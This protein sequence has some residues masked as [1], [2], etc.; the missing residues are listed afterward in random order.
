MSAPKPPS[1]DDLLAHGPFL[2]RITRRLVRAG[3]DADD[4]MQDTWLRVLERPPRN[5]ANL[6][7]W[8]ARVTRNRLGEGRRRRQRVD[9]QP[10]ELVP[11][12]AANQA[13]AEAEL[14]RATLARTVAN[15]VLELEE[16]YRTVVVMRYFEDASTQRIA[17]RL[18][19]SPNTVGSQLRR[20]LER[21][22][23][24]L[25]RDLGQD[26]SSDL[27]VLSPLLALGLE[28]PA[29]GAYTSTEALA[30][31]GTWRVAT[32]AAWVLALGTVASW[33][34]F[35]ARPATDDAS[36]AVA[37]SAGPESSEDAAPRSEKSPTRTTATATVSSSPGEAAPARARS[38]AP[39]VAVTAVGPGGEPVAG[40]H[41]LVARSD[42]TLGQGEGLLRFDPE[43]TTGEDGR[44][45]LPLEPAQRVDITDGV[46][47]DFVGVIVSA[48]GFA[49][50]PQHYAPFPETGSADFVVPLVPANA[51][52][53]GSTRDASGAPVA[54]ALVE[55]IAGPEQLRETGGG[56]YVRYSAIGHKSDRRGQ[57]RFEDLARTRHR[58]RIEAR[59]FLP[60][61]GF[62]EETGDGQLRYDATL[63][64][65]GV[66]FGRLSQPD[67]TPAVGV[68]VRAEYGFGSPARSKQWTTTGE[69]GR[70]ELSG[71]PDGRAWIFARDKA[72]PSRAAFTVSTIA[73]AD[74][75][76]AERWDARLQPYPPLQLRFVHEDG[77]PLPNVLV[78]AYPDSVEDAWVRRTSANADG[79]AELAGLP[80]ENIAI[81]VF[82]GI[83]DVQAG[84]PPRANFRGLSASAG[85][86]E[87]QVDRERLTHSTLKGRLL[88][89]LAQPFASATLRLASTGGRHFYSTPVRADGSFENARLASGSFE[90]YASCGE[91]GTLFL[92][93]LEIGT[94]EA[95][96]LG[97]VLMPEPV[98][99]APKPLELQLEG[100]PTWELL[101]LDEVAG[102]GHEKIWP[103]TTGSGSPPRAFRVFPGAYRWIVRCGGKE[104]A[105][106]SLEA[107]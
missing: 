86:H 20:G 33:A 98:R 99:L 23:V 38:R 35:L 78:L 17:T 79:R 97:E 10:L 77:T 50:S 43:S 22:R 74:G 89:H 72:H 21:L 45:E 6:P 91:H 88:D 41:V 93:S 31:G 25:E 37:S 32:A 29:P 28:A 82:G 58:V 12:L 2:A 1:L 8:L 69:D 14:E 16:P 4:A 62:V 34:V 36:E 44:V 55:V 107:L 7:A 60:H 83:D 84:A 103:V 67:G 73:A 19:R 64:R 100:E 30:T 80:P 13:S 65:G 81:D 75:E 27:R 39:G 96:D 51:T 3:E 61:W 42:D 47:L 59:G 76:H 63:Q 9:V 40:A 18:Q 11:D 95:V 71:L 104:V 26:P 68:E 94:N 24:R 15:A 46:D 106:Q 92:Q 90:V 85:E 49:T 101:E 66:L 54:G 56:R 102:W 70:Y 87:L 57:F 48:S 53:L 5:A 52:L 105:R